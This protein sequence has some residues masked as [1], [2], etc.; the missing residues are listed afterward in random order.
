M[1]HLQEFPLINTVTHGKP[2]CRKS[3]VHLCVRFV[4]ECTVCSEVAVQCSVHIE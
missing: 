3:F 1:L 2:C 4:V